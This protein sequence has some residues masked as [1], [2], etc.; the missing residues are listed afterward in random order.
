[1]SRNSSVIALSVTVSLITS[2]LTFVALQIWLVP[3]LKTGK[4]EVKPEAPAPVEVPRLLGLRPDDAKII[5]KEKN[6]LLSLAK[7]AP[8]PTVAV[9]LIHTQAP[10]AGSMIV[11][12]QSIVVEVSAGPPPAAVP[13]VVGKNVAAGRSELEKL[14]LVVQVK[15]REDKNAT[16]DQILSQNIEP[17]QAVT[18]GATIELVVAQAASASVVPDYKGRNFN[19]KDITEEL[20]KLGLKLGKVRYVDVS[21]QRNGYIYNTTP[22]DGGRLPGAVRR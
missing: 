14:G 1:M 11:S 2:A 20:E 3:H 15:P 9:G 21:D 4:T 13:L 8:H 7:T 5:L 22:E 16:P 10:L 18:A 17:G 19:K 6:L 12:G